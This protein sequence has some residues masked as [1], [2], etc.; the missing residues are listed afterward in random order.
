MPRALRVASTSLVL[1]AGIVFGVV[2]MT[3]VFAAVVFPTIH[4]LDPTLPDF[5]GY[6]GP[7]WSLAAGILAERVFKIG[8]VVIGIALGGAL[9]SALALLA[10]R[11]TEGLPVLRLGLVLLTLGLFVAQIGWLQPRMND[12]AGAYRAA[13]MAG[14]ETAAGEAKEQFDSM[15]PTA[16]KLLGATAL[17]AFALFGVSAWAASGR[18]PRPGATAT[19]GRR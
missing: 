5:A 13:A 10:G 9:L 18:N 3:G 19:A 16:S 4:K 14:D 6:S 17:S 2:A 15:H 1:C 11:R 12:A 8:F 7:H